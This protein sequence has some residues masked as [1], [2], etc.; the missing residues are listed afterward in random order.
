MEPALQ[1]ICDEVI[2]GNRTSVEEGVR[3]AMA[4]GLPPGSVPDEG[5]ISAM[6]EVGIRFE[7]QELCVSEMLVAARAMQSGLAI[8]K[9]QLAAGGSRAIGKVVLGTVKGDLHDIGNSLVGMMLEGR[10]IRDHRSLDGRTTSSF[11]RGGPRTWRATGGFVRTADDH[12]AE[13]EV[14]H[15]SA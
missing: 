14:H 5:L 2:P 10:R 3:Q 7:R 11:C 15:R 4:A 8:L 13:Y 9:P 6:G 1:A 12:D